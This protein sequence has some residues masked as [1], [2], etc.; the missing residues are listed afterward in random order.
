M[1]SQ[2]VVR[3]AAARPASGHAGGGGGVAKYVGGSLLAT[4]L[5]VGGTMAYAGV[6]D[7]FRVVVEDSVPA[8]DMVME[9]VLGKRTLAEKVME[10]PS[11]L[12]IISAV[13]EKHPLPQELHHPQPP[14]LEVPA[15]EETTVVEVS[16]PQVENPTVVSEVPPQVE[17]AAATAEVS[18]EPVEVGEAGDSLVLSAV[19]S[20]LNS[21]T[22]EDISVDKVDIVTNKDNI[23]EIEPE[24]EEL[25][26]HESEPKV[27]W[28][29][30]SACAALRRFSGT[31]C[32]LFLGLFFSF[33][34]SGP[35]T[36]LQEG[37]VLG[38]CNLA[39]S[40]K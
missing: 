12:K 38:L 18:T 40:F 2:Q 14:V 23:I 3:Q 29:E 16:P 39:W 34:F 31:K 13:Q 36:F 9:M 21:A 37:V 15:L 35:H 27:N 26:D 20:V 4:S 28:S 10:V 1:T 7:E 25:N 24:L 11:K 8:A 30:Q 6:D 22:E 32:P 19:D 5:G 33:F 17:P